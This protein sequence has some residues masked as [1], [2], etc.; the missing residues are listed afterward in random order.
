MPDLTAN[1]RTI[2][3]LAD[4]L[5]WHADPDC[6]VLDTAELLGAAATVA[7]AIVDVCSDE[8]LDLYRARDECDQFRALLIR[9]GYLDDPADGIATA[10]TGAPLPLED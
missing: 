10:G 1:Q 3:I 9:E 8:M 7:D 2:Y 6:D 4:S 5:S